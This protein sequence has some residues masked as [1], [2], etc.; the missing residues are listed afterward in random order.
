MIRFLQSN[1]V[2]ML[3]SFGRLVAFILAFGWLVVPT[4][5]VQL[6]EIAAMIH[7]NFALDSVAFR[8]VTLVDARAYKNCFGCDLFCKIPPVKRLKRLE[9]IIDKLQSP[10]LDGKNANKLVSLI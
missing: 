4:K 9:T 3:G 8:H 7:L 2:N 6:I 5:Q 10:T 1:I